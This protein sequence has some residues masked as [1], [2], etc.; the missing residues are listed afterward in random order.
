MEDMSSIVS[1]LI[2]YNAS[3]D[4]SAKMMNDEDFNKQYQAKYK[5][6]KEQMKS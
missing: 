2:G 1:S 4:S 6:I 5:I 3:W